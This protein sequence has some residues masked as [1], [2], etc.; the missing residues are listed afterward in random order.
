MV[1]LKCQYRPKLGSASNN[2]PP[3][4]GTCQVCYRK[5]QV[6]QAD[7]YAKP[8][9]KFQRF[10]KRNIICGYLP[11]K[12]IAE[13]KQWDLVHV[14]LIYKYDKSI[15]KNLQ[16]GSTTNNYVSITC[17]TMIGSATGWFKI[18]K[19]P[20]FDLDDSAYG[21]NKYMDKSSI[22]VIQLFNNTWLCRYPRPRK[23]MFW[24]WIWV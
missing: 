16:G 15:I 12:N 1:P 14:D 3:K 11:P 4:Y 8:C 17:M 19:F 2:W 23:F 22:R 10:K 13:L 5:G 7:I 24:Q 21:N 9:E 20:R 6:E 18:V